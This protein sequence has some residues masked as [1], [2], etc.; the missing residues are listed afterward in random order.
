MVNLLFAVVMFFVMVTASEA[1]DFKMATW[2]G[3]V[4]GLQFAQ[5][6]GG[7]WNF[8]Y[9]GRVAQGYVMVDVPAGLMRIKDVLRFREEGS[10]KKYLVVTDK[11]VYL[12]LRDQSGVKR[13]SVTIRI[14]FFCLRMEE[15]SC[16]EYLT[17]TLKNGTVM[18]S[19]GVL[20]VSEDYLKS[21]VLPDSK[22]FM[23]FFVSTGDEP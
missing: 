21:G 16:M 6:S 3:Y 8:V 12:R 5:L 22:L 10:E 18:G 20:A 1:E 14:V 17:K 4:Q 15:S 23:T 9:D 2:D 7:D 13:R 11:E 19:L